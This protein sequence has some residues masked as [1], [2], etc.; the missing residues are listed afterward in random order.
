MV[1]KSAKHGAP[2]YVVQHSTQVHSYIYAH[3]ISTWPCTVSLEHTQ[4]RA[5]DSELT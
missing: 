5:T 1:P 3:Y 2:P 4:C